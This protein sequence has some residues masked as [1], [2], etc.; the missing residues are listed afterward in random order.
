VSSTNLTHFI[1]LRIYTF[2]LHFNGGGTGLADCARRAKGCGSL[3]GPSAPSSH[4]S[5]RDPGWTGSSSTGG[6][7]G[8]GSSTSGRTRPGRHSGSRCGR[9]PLPRPTWGRISSR[10]R[11]GRPYNYEVVQG[12][13]KSPGNREPDAFSPSQATQGRG[14]GRFA[15]DTD[16]NILVVLKAREG[17]VFMKKNRRRRMLGGSRS[18]GSKGRSEIRLRGVRQRR[19][20]TLFCGR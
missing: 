8:S 19:F 11:I 6:G 12:G 4:F 7:G 5:C 20:S 2:S 16:G 15:V 14:G 1:H 18:Q 9:S 17:E 10:A 3:D 13:S